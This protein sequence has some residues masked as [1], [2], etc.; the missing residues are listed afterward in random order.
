[1]SPKISISLLKS[2]DK[3]GY[4]FMSEVGIGLA[5]V[6]THLPFCLLAV[7]YSCPDVHLGVFRP[8]SHL[9]LAKRM[10][11]KYEMTD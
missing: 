5:S 1:M 10:L 7:L 2:Y 4:F 9:V 8:A 11:G 3:R 6:A